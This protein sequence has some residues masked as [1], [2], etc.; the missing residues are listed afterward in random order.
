MFIRTQLLVT[1]PLFALP[2][3]ACNILSK[4]RFF[5]LFWKWSGIPSSFEDRGFFLFEVA[6]KLHQLLIL[7]QKVVHQV[8]SKYWSYCRD[9][10]AKHHLHLPRLQN[11]HAHIFIKNFLPILLLLLLRFCFFFG[12]LWGFGGNT[13]SYPTQA[14]YDLQLNRHVLKFL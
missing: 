13:P 14:T 2:F 9:L 11:Y 6:L 3:F 5:I 8:N 10:F 4:I 1:Q 12:S 7:M